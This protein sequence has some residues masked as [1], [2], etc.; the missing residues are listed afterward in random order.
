MLIERAAGDIGAPRERGGLISRRKQDKGQYGVP[1]QSHPLCT[2]TQ[3]LNINLNL[4]MMTSL[5]G[6]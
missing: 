5:I 3:G 6:Y 4:T 2:W 1:R